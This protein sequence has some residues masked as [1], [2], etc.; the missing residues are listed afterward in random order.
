MLALMIGDL[1]NMLNAGSALED[2]EK[3]VDP[4]SHLLCVAYFFHS[5][6][7]SGTY[8]NDHLSTRD[9]F[10]TS[11]PGEKSLGTRLPIFWSWRTVRAPGPVYSLLF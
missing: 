7:K 8:I 10:S 3:K 4:I 5:V 9:Y 1:E 2:P 6:N 11:F